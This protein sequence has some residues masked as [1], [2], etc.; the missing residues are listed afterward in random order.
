MEAPERIW[1]TPSIDLPKLN[2]V[3]DKNSIEYIRKDAFVDETC[4]FLRNNID[5][6][7]TI[8]HDNTWC[9]RD[10]FIKKFC[11]YMRGE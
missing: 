10:E 1:I 11:K 7:L 4:E 9:K 8:Y 2:G 6:Q 5:K 3:M